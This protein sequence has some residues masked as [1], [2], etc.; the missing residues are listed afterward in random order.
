MFWCLQCEICIRHNSQGK[1]QAKEGRVPQAWLSFW[2]NAHGLY[3]IEEARRLE[4]CLVIIDVF[5]IWIEVFPSSTPDSLT[6]AKALCKRIRPTFGVPQII[7]QTRKCKEPNTVRVSF[8]SPQV[9][10]QVKVKVGVHQ[11]HQMKELVWRQVGGT[12]QVYLPPQQPSR[13]L[14]A[15]PGFTC[16]TVTL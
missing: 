9:Q 4:Y 6:V 7:L 8:V 12:Y 10:G 16:H 1:P 15:P 11:N 5:S 2:G 13:S 3:P 14:N